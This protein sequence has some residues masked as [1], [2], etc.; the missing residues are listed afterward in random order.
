MIK[1]EEILDLSIEERLLVI[2]RI[3]KS[4]DHPKD[5]QIPEAHAQ[6]LDS[7]LSRYENGQTRFVN[8][9]EVK[10]KLNAA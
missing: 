3:W 2:E 4:I 8:W 9:S 5:I 10:S 6:E 7:R 1:M